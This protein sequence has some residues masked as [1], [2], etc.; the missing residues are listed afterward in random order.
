MKVGIV[1][2]GH[3]KF[4]NRSDAT[5]QELTFEPFKEAIEDAKNLRREDIDALVV[6][7]VP[8][9]HMQ[10]SLPGVV[11]EYVQLNKVDAETGHFR[12]DWTGSETHIVSPDIR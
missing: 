12:F 9:Y 4:G 6:G 10:R 5:V 8:E 7:S 2:I 1:G 3:G 11:A